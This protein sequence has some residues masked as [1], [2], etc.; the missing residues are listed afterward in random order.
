MFLLVLLYPLIPFMVLIGIIRAGLDIGL[1]LWV[2]K[3]RR[4]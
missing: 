1:A 4:R 2:F 3:E